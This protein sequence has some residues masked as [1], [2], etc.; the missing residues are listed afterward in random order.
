MPCAPQQADCRVSHHRHLV[1]SPPDMGLALIFAQ[2][3]IFDVVQAILHLPVPAFQRRELCRIAHR[4]GQT[5]D[6]VAHL[7]LGHALGCPPPCVLEHLHQVGPGAISSQFARHTDL[8]LLKPTVAFRNRPIGLNRQRLH[9]MH[10]TSCCLL[11]CE[12]GKDL[13]YIG[14]QR[15]LILLDDQQVITTGSTTCAHSACWQYNASPVNTRPC[16]SICRIAWGATLSSP[17]CCWTSTMSWVS[18]PAR[19]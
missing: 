16:Q 7:L 3:H 2:C 9:G 14:Q 4:F 8:P 12:R 1:C 5:G 15:R 18:T 6:A 11:S 13:H 19:S 17:S 10:A